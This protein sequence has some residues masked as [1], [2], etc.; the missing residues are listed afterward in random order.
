MIQSALE[1]QTNVREDVTITEGPCYS[2]VCTLIFLETRDGDQTSEDGARTA[3]LKTIHIDPCQ[4]STK[5]VKQFHGSF[6]NT[7]RKRLPVPSPC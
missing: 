4:E 5:G 2:F 7:Q 3:I 6:H 1:L